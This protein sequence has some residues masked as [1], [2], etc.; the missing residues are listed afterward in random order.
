M[1]GWR[2]LASV[3]FDEAFKLE[4]V[5]AFAA[6]GRVGESIHFEGCADGTYRVLNGASS[7]SSAVAV[8]A[9]PYPFSERCEKFDTLGVWHT[10]EH[11]V[12][13]S[14][15]VGELFPMLPIALPLSV[16]RFHD[17]SVDVS[18]LSSEKIREA[19]L[20][21]RQKMLHESF[22]RGKAAE[23]DCKKASSEI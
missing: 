16:I 7:D 14:E 3:G 1:V 13:S 12:H 23:N 15:W 5:L 19:S 4:P 11:F 17:P 9:S 2:V 20:L 10:G 18:P 22:C 21:L 6:V 8:M